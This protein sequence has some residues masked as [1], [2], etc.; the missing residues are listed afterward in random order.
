MLLVRNKRSMADCSTDQCN[1]QYGFH[2]LMNNHLHRFWG[3]DEQAQT[4]KVNISEDEKSYTIEL[5]APGLTK[6]DLKIDLEK[7][8]LTISAEVKKETEEKKTR[9]LKREFNYYG[10][11]RNFKIPESSDAT[12]IK[13]SY[14]NGILTVVLPKKEEASTPASKTITIG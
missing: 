1:N 7:D 9:F 14:T 6:E 2:P 3:M 5:A 12:A 10:F 4:P 13:A 11:K 8:V